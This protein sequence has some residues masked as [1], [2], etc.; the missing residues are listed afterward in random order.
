MLKKNVNPDWWQSPTPSPWQAAA[1]IAVDIFTSGFATLSILPV[2][3]RLLSFPDFFYSALSDVFAF[4]FFLQTNFLLL[5]SWLLRVSFLLLLFSSH[6]PLFLFLGGEKNNPCLTV[7]G[8]F[9]NSFASFPTSGRLLLFILLSCLSLT[10]KHNKVAKNIRNNGHH[11]LAFL[12]L[13]GRCSS[14]AD[15]LPDEWSVA[16]CLVG[17]GPPSGYHAM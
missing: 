2:R 7:W 4:F 12:C 11:L 1:V 8:L 13:L 14:D 15:K 5:S 3:H 17:T 9:C 6:F 10:P 16:S